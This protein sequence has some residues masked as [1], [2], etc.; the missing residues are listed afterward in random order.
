MAACMEQDQQYYPR[1]ERVRSRRKVLQTSQKNN[2]HKGLS[3]GPPSE[4]KVCFLCGQAGHIRKDCSQLQQAVSS[5]APQ[6]PQKLVQ[7]PAQSYTSVQLL[8]VEPQPQQSTNRAPVPQKSRCGFVACGPVGRGQV[9]RVTGG[10]AMEE[11]VNAVINGVSVEDI[12]RKVAT[13]FESDHGMPINGKTIQE[14]MFIFF[15]KL[16]NC[17]L[18]LVEEFCVKEFRC[19]GFG[20][21]LMFLEKYACL[22]PHELCKFLTGDG[23]G[24]CPLEVCMLQ[25]HFVVLVSQALNSLWEDEKITK[26]NIPLLLGSSS[27]RLVSKPLKMV[28]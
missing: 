9:F 28:R 21:F 26:L 15:R 5:L 22:L 14:K 7:C 24:K 23:N 16:C 12:I 13:F 19:L 6:N 25:D 17:E 3:R 18:W 11:R 10:E 8:P 2:I 20:E 27:H 4:S 1:H